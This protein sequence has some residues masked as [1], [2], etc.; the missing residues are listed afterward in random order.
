PMVEITEIS[1]TMP[2]RRRPRLKRNAIMSRRYL[3]LHYPRYGNVDIAIIYNIKMRNPAARFPA[4][5]LN[6]H[7]LSSVRPATP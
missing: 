2:P 6:R 7:T 1:D 3:A 5:P 4:A